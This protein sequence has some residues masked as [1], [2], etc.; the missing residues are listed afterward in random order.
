MT[1]KSKML[2]VLI[3]GGDGMLGHQLFKQLAPRHETRVTLRQDL[4]AYEQFG[5]FSKDNA[6]AGIDVRVTDRL[7]A[8]LADFRPDF[9]IN[10]IGMVKQRPEGQEH[11]SNL[12]VNALLP[13]RVA[14]LCKAIQAPLIHIGTDCVFSGKRGNYSESD[15]P[16]PVDVYGYSK[17]LGEVV[18]EGVLTLRTSIIGT[19][20]S[21]K[22]S[23]VEWFL[24]E[25]GS[26]KGYKEAIFSGFTTMELS[27]IID[28][29]L[30]SGFHD[31]WGLYHVSSSPISK[32]DL[33]AMLRDKLALTLRI[34]PDH[35]VQCDRSLDS[36][37]F[38]EKFGYTPPSWDT[39]LDELAR[40]IRE[41]KR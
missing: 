3:L 38:R 5:L 12:E 23:L 16:D 8:V 6:Y 40:E 35:A 18:S 17:L 2:R 30:V 24:G 33:L 32:H 14:L 7:L 20:L 36:S 29:L 34:E 4:S 28:H 19:E 11:I 15:P 1:K 41:Q 26:I 25:S 22:S 9:V 39:M 21:R 37:L 10:A 31:A 13:H 27:R